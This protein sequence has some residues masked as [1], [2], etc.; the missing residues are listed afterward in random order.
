MAATSEASIVYGEVMVCGE[1]VVATH[2]ETV[3]TESL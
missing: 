3:T 1:S 2:E